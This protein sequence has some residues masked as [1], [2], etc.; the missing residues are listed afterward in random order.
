MK[1]EYQCVELITLLKARCFIL[2][3][4]NKV[5]A[6]SIDGVSFWRPRGA[7]AAERFRNQ[8]SSLIVSFPPCCPFYFS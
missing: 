8:P 7:T 1:K 4:H 2:P 5:L 3:R 6:V